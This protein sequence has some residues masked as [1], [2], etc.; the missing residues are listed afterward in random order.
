VSRIRLKL[1]G[2]PPRYDVAHENQRNRSLERT[3]FDNQKKW[4]DYEIETRLI[5]TDSNGVRWSVTVDTSGN[6][7]TTSL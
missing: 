6:L 7:V 4:E 3:D 1:A 2:A 5:L